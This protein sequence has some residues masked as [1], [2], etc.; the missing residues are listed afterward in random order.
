MEEKEPVVEVL[1]DGQQPTGHGE[2]RDQL[3]AYYLVPY[4]ARPAAAPRPVTVR[5]VKRRDRGK[6]LERRG[7]QAR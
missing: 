1:K 4:A 5:S 3:P 7:V 2:G 6:S